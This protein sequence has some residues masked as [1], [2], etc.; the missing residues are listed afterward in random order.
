MNNLETLHQRMGNISRFAMYFVS[1]AYPDLD[2][3]LGLCDLHFKNKSYFL[4]D[5]M[6]Y[7][8]DLE[9]RLKLFFLCG[10]ILL[11]KD[12][13][14]DQVKEDHK[15]ILSRKRKTTDDHPQGDVRKR[16]TRKT[17]V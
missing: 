16:V 6:T 9:M 3:L 10:I 17:R 14:K 1:Y 2:V 11:M 13:T 5:V 8:K 15:Q 12:H 4:V 7:A